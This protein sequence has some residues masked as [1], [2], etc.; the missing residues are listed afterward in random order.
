M[1]VKLEIQHNL[2]RHYEYQLR[3]QNLVF[4]VT[5]SWLILK[6]SI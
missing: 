3:N 2:I 6:Y 4:M 1:D 5:F